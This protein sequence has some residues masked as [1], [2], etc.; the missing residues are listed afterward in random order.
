MR[1]TLFEGTRLGYAADSL[2]GLS[3]GDALGEQFFQYG[4]RYADLAAGDLPPPVWMWTDDTEMAC[5][6]Y[7]VL[8]TAGRIDQDRLASAFAQRCHPERGYGVGAYAVLSLIRDGAPWPAASAAAFGGVGSYGNGAAMRV[9]PLGAYLADSPARAAREAA[10]AAEITHAHPEG[11]AGAVAAS[12][13]AAARMAGR[14]PAAGEFIDAV[15]AWVPRSRIRAALSRA[16]RMLRASPVEA[17]AILGTGEHITA[18]DTVPYAIWV[19]A[20]FLTDYQAAVQACIQVGGDIDT[21]S[22]IVGGIVAAHTGVTGIPTAWLT[23][24]EP[25]PSWL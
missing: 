24:R 21:T 2:A 10:A 1:T 22:A 6:V 12:V 17:A 15:R 16:R 14:T 8:R 9:A 20:R 18:Q 23:A 3:V 7:W 11:V 4:R 25:L 19:A 5:S 13:A